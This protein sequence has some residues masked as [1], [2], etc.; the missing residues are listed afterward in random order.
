[1]RR[2]PLLIHN[3]IVRIARRLIRQI[4]SPTYR[5]TLVRLSS[6]R[7]TGTRSSL[8]EKLPILRRISR[9]TDISVL[10]FTIIKNSRLRSNLFVVVS[11]WRR[12]SFMNNV[13]ENWPTSSI[14][15]TGRATFRAVPP[16][17]VFSGVVIRCRGGMPLDLASFDR[18]SKRHRAIVIASRMKIDRCR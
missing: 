8:F 17:N 18:K 10:T 6:A 2:I 14:G 4:D 1:M 13:G 9:Y 12:T 5:T 15:Y 16:T 7:S 3:N 11:N